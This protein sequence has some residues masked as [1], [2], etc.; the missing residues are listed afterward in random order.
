MAARLNTLIHLV[1]LAA[2]FVQDSDTWNFQ[3]PREKPSEEKLA[4]EKLAEEMLPGEKVSVT[5]TEDHLKRIIIDPESLKRMNFHLLGLLDAIRSVLLRD[6][7]DAEFDQLRQRAK[8]A[9]AK[10]AGASGAT[11]ATSGGEAQLLTQQLY[12]FVM[13][14]LLSLSNSLKGSRRPSQNQ[15]QAQEQGQAQEQAQA[16]EQSQTQPH[17][18][19]AEACDASDA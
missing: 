10:Q 1:I 15:E 7:V 16:Q 13:Q 9:D 8:Q 2:T 17:D 18:S 19:E 5:L 14:E 6:M 3:I 4:G 12:D 11:R